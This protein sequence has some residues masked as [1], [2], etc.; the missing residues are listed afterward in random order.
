MKAQAPVKTWL[1]KKLPTRPI[2]NTASV[3]VRCPWNP[4]TGDSHILQLASSPP[5]PLVTQMP[6]S[7]AW[8]GAGMFRVWMHSCDRIQ[9]STRPSFPSTLHVTTLHSVSLRHL[10]G[11]FL[12]ARLKNLDTSRLFHGSSLEFQ[13]QGI[14][15]RNRTFR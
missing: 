9:A 5:P 13:A 4:E 3:Q 7:I 15:W 2:M 12:T 14:R 1:A 10:P 11:P 8:R 6:S